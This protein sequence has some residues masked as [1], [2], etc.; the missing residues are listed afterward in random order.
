MLAGVLKMKSC[1]FLSCIY[2]FI[3][4]PGIVIAGGHGTVTIFHAGS[5]SVPMAAMEKAFEKKYPEIDIQRESSGSAKAA[6]KICELRKPCDIMVAADY[7][8]IDKL[9]M[10]DF[11]DINIR[12]ASNRMVL[13]YTNKSRYS[14]SINDKNWM[15]I[16][17]KDDVVWGQSDPNLDPCG[18]RTLMVLQLAEKYYKRPGLYNKIISEHPERNIRPKAV[19]LISLLLTGNMDYIWEYRSVAVQHHLKYIELPEQINLGNYKFDGN[20]AVAAVA[21]SGK[22]P[23]TTMTMRG[24]SI[25]YGVTL[26][27][28]AP[29]RE[30]A[31]SFLQFMFEPDEGL[32]ILQEKGQ[33]PFVPVRVPSE[34]MK[35]LLPVQ[36]QSSVVVKK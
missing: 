16:L 9:L 22:K 11:S 27:K 30:A 20:Y 33:P 28:N 31:I 34:N 18:Y 25:T 24:K 4:F 12:F 36:L 19:E 10:P 15:D 35:A 1:Y 8:V 26:L 3:F 14:D 23:G 7:K 2:F 6:R 17:Q 29:N 32:K 21:V 5:L 13:C